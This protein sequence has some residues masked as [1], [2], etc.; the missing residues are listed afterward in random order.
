MSAI[1]G[2]LCRITVYGPDGRADLAV[3]VSTTVADL[4]PV[5]LSH[6]R[7]N[8][9][10]EEQGSWILQRLGETPLDPDGTP[11]TLDWLEGE[12]L[13]LRPAADP[14]PELDFDDLA[15]GIA[16]SVAQRGDR[17]KP[18]YNAVL[19]RV[20]SGVVALVIALAL[21]GDGP[22][23]LHAGFALGLGVVFIAGAAVVAKKLADLMLTRLAGLA[24]CVFV[25]LAGLITAD[26]AADMAALTP[27]GIVVAG[28]ATAVSAA[29]LLILRRFVADDIPFAPFV[30]VF[31][32][33][34]ALIVGVWLGSGFDLTPGRVA[35]VLATLF[36]GVVIFVPKVAIRA[37][38]LRGPQL[39]RNAADLQQDIDPAPADEVSARTATADRYISVAMVSAAAVS[40]GSY[41]FILAEPGWIGWTMVS[42]LAAGLL[43]RS[44]SFV[45]VW[46]RISLVTAGTVGLGLVVLFHAQ[47]FPPE[48]R[49]VL[50]VGVLLALFAVVQGALRPV[51]RRLLPIWGHLA[52]I[53]D[54]VTGL[55]ALPL[56]LQ[57]LGV[58]AWA[59]G[60]AG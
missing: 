24:G 51:N 17:W 22:T 41:P 20:L 8:P 59:R 45:G 31:L 26:G 15:D 1:A 46:Q 16:T 35:G 37:A 12:Q 38:F 50:L 5:L 23:G 7:R 25:G 14:L 30:T 18:E 54:T 13:Y 55:A 34:L 2:E 29:V 3:P 60:L 39:P 53:F 44:R 6:T 57:L 56:L 36:L 52:N 33:A 27:Q 21:L 48:W 40:V 10:A 49:T 58:Y 32:V 43:L 47:R 11:E 28:G 4:V 19:F 9:E 42:L